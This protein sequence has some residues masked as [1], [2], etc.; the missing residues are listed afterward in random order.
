MIYG[1]RNL[2]IRRVVY[3]AKFTE[4]YGGSKL[5]RLRD[6]FEQVIKTSPQDVSSN[7]ATIV[8]TKVLLLYVCG[9]GREFRIT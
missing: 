9:C 8:E 1:K 6:L 2:L 7:I 4:R 3:L 5:E